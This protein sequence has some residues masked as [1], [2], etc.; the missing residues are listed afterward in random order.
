M[1]LWFGVSLFSFNDQTGALAFRQAPD[2]ENLGELY[3]NNGYTVTIDAYSYT[4]PGSRK[5]DSKTINI[6]VTDVD[7]APE[8]ASDATAVFRLPRAKRAATAMFTARTMDPEGDNVS[9]SLSAADDVL[10]NIDP[11][12]GA[13]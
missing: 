12:S 8:F 7:E 3:S 5:Y 1:Y 2:F 4:I 11:T 6:M 10:F 13:Y 9:Y